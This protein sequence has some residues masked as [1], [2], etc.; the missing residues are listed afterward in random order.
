MRFEP[1][2]LEGAYLIHLDRREDERG[3]FARAFCAEKFAGNGLETRYLQANLSHNARAGIV[4]GMHYQKPPHEEVKLVRCVSGAIFDAIIDLRENSPTYRTWFGATLSAENGTL[5]YVPR[6]FAH[7]Y[8]AL[9]DGA[10]VHYMVSACYT[11]DAE[12]GVHHADPAIGIAWPMPVSETSPKDA[13]LP[14]IDRF[15]R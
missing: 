9:T 3:F 13:A 4:R 1:A 15:T 11:P 14:M 10:L 2:P 12:A 6:G 7:G 5:M 8:Q